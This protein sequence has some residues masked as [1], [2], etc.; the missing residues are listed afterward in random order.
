MATVRVMAA[1]RTRVADS[2]RCLLAAGCAALVLAL[3]IFAASPVAHDW[4]HLDTDGAAQSDDGCAVKLFAAG[5]SVP[6]APIS[7]PV[8]GETPRVISPAT[9][10]EVLLVSPRYLRQ[11]ERG[12]PGLV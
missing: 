11:P 5:V 4:L 7:V 12:P 3:T 9:A 1:R 2:L 6:L 8:P 10:T